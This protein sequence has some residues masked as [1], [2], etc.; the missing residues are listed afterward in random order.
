MF[1]LKT[2]I[3][4]KVYVFSFLVFICLVINLV[5][6]GDALSQT[7]PPPSAKIHAPDW[8]VKHGKEFVKN[9]DFCKACHAPDL[10]GGFTGIKCDLC[11]LLPAHPPD[12]KE[13]HG[14]KFL[15]NQSQC[16]LCHGR[17]PFSGKKQPFT[18]NCTRCHAVNAD[19]GRW[20]AES[21]TS[22][23]YL[24]FLQT[25]QVREDRFSKT[26]TA[27]NNYAGFHLSERSKQITASSQVRFTRE[28]LDEKENH[29]DVKVGRRGFG[30]N[31]DYF[32]MDGM[33]LTIKPAK[34]FNVMAYAGIP[35]YIEQE[36]IDGNLGFVSGLSLRMKEYKYTKA[37][38]DFTYQKKDFSAGG[39]NLNDKMYA[40]AS[41]SKGISIFKLYGLGEYDLTETLP[42]ALTAGT[43]IYPFVKKISFLLEGSYF[44]ES[45][46]DNF[47]SIFTIF[48]EGALWQGRSGFA[49]NVIK[50]LSLSD[51]FSFQRYEVLPSLS[52]NGYN[53]SM[54]ASYLFKKIKLE[55]AL[56]YN[57][58]KSYGGTLHGFSLSLYEDWTRDFYTRAF[59]DFITYTKVTNNDDKAFDALLEVGYQLRRG[60]RLA[61]VAEYVNN[62]VRETDLKGT[63]KLNYLFDT[64][65][66]E[67][68]K[69]KEKK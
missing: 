61:A 20:Q 26:E 37:K 68:E 6:F 44:N 7:P 45:R 64:K 59:V 47:D 35:R 19:I 63:I 55:T 57:F 23:M 60:L 29:L 3:S 30:S 8:I 49:V 12:W 48:S 62:N 32:L 41:L 22:Q 2:K 25:A 51:Y 21:Q 50:N 1:F 36:D 58:Y 43:E 14:D 33:D 9:R 53:N 38:I 54:G 56:N 40:A 18:M 34:F 31:V 17:D 52:K 69:Q 11:H 5:F 24:S 15:E 13:I 67:F 42:T 10:T 4:K 65:F 27:T 46:N 66:L 16:T 28:W 39:L